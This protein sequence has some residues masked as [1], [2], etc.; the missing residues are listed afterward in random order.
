[1]GDI[2]Q[3]RST[4]DVPVEVALSNNSFHKKVP[5]Y[6]THQPT[7]IQS[8]HTERSQKLARPKVIIPLEYHGISGIHGHLN[9]TGLDPMK[10]K[11]ESTQRNKIR[12]GGLQITKAS[13]MEYP[14]KPN[15]Q[16][17]KQAF[18]QKNFVFNPAILCNIVGV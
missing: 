12:S 2:I 9:F 13:N 14:G 7:I 4:M 18:S 15:H 16:P 11:V 6:P 3:L 1:M 8:Q 17:F 5:K 10:C